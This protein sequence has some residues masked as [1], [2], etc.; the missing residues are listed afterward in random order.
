MKAHLGAPFAPK[1][2]YTGKTPCQISP[3]IQASQQSLSCHDLG[4]LIH[5]CLS[6]LHQEQPYDDHDTH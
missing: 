6:A 1:W 4:P 3:E 2:E 5:P